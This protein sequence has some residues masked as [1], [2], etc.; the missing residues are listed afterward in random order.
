MDK[1]GACV[2]GRTFFFSAFIRHG[3]GFVLL[4]ERW[5]VKVTWRSV[6]YKSLWLLVTPHRR[7]VC[8][9][10]S[11]NTNKIC[12]CLWNV[13]LTVTYVDRRVFKGHSV[14]LT[15]PCYIYG[16]NDETRIQTVHES[17]RAWKKSWLMTITHSLLITVTWWTQLWSAVWCGSLSVTLV[18][19][20]LSFRLNHKIIKLMC[21]PIMCPTHTLT[22]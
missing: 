17:V 19:S 11:G 20:Q 16:H 3:G 8:F 13:Q 12:C 21:R 5:P 7:N 10:V 14:H 22:L 18:L 2:G 9:P 15:S 1:G 6:V 4:V